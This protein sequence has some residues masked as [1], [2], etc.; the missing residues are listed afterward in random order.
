[1]DVRRLQ[2]AT[3]YC[4]RMSRVCGGV[5][6]QWGFV[7]G[8]TGVVSSVLMCREL[9]A[10]DGCVAGYSFPNACFSKTSQTKSSQAKPFQAKTSQSINCGAET[11]AKHNS[12]SPCLLDFPEFDRI[13]RLKTGNSNRRMCLR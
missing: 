8:P 3:E 10:F 6:G 13:A 1:M 5:P 11:Y 2:R 9:P 4:C 7:V 12:T